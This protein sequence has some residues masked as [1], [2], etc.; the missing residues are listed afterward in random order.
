M[1]L[2]F[3]TV[4][5]TASF[6]S[7]LQSVFNETFLSALKQHG[8]T[9]LLVQYG[10]DGQ[11]I[12][13]NFTKKNPEGS[14]ARHGIDI[15][16]LDFNQAGLGAEMRLAQANAELD[17]EGGMIISH[18]GSGTILEAM[19]LGIPLVVVPNPS[20]KDNHQKELANELQKQGYVIASNVNE[21]S[22]AVSEAEALRSHM[23]RWPPVRG[24]NQ[25]QPTLEQVMSD[26]LGFVD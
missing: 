18:A 15:T 16:G 21:V 11:A 9:H 20:L 3:V 17:Q 22:E 19:R 23:L 25:R 7:L 1:K 14:V 24:R 26:E 2:C 8:Y 10:K 5:A 12:C 4:G 13:E 6:E